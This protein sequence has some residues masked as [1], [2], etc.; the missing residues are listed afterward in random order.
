MAFS[1]SC[2]LPLCSLFL[3]FLLPLISSS[4]STITIPL[5]FSNSNSPQDLYQNLA[6]LASVSLARAHRIKNP[7]Q[8]AAS[9]T[10]T[11]PLLPHSYG[12]YSISLSF[13][14][15][16]QT[17]PFVFDTG[18][19]F[20][21]FP[22]TKRYLCKNCSAP[23]TVIPTFIPRQS[24]SAKI[25]GC[26]NPKCGWI[27][28]QTDAQNRCQDCQSGD[29]KKNC[30]QI[31]PPYIIIYGSGSTGGIALLDTL[32]FP[33]KKFR[34]FLVGCSLFSSRAP[35][36]IAGFG[37]G[38]VSLPNQL[39]IKK[40]S[41]CLLSHRFDDSGKSTS[42]LL[43]SDSKKTGNL[44]YTPML[45]NPEVAGKSSLSVYYYLSLRKI[46][47]GGKKV[48]IPYEHLVPNSDGKGGT[49]VDSGS[50]FTF[51]SSPVYE[52]VTG[53]IINQAK[54]YYPRVKK[55]ES[56]TGLAPCFNLSGQKDV[57]LP[58]MKFHFKGGAEMK[59][60]LANYFSLVG[61]NEVACLTM[62][63]D[64]FGQIQTSG[65]SIILGNFQMQNFF[66]EYDLKNERFGFRQQFCK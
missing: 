34:D 56:F 42:L 7:V 36:G 13:G 51:L 55:I 37:R 54:K 60:P 64:G 3:A 45:K 29:G 24:S 48:K 19:N 4:P 22:C 58:E 35:S 9:S 65:P 52:S 39:G 40:F 27:H 20:V 26:L 59:L 25:V 5:A 6:N 11:T 16:P 32:D 14:T 33:N 15:P 61:D 44:S 49:I 66:V 50:T 63:T 21:W 43:D 30:K 57:V 2:C 53:E 8:N 62:I 17:I 23:S 1:S 47:V 31:C 18:S 38:L 28:K 10:S 46:S 41:Y 12:G